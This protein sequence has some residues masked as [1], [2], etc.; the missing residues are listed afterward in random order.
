ML[1]ALHHKSKVKIGFTVE[2][3]LGLLKSSLPI[4]LGTNDFTCFQQHGSGS[5]Q[6]EVNTN[7]FIIWTRAN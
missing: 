4:N 7:L 6:R 3:M 5:G 1:I 2:E